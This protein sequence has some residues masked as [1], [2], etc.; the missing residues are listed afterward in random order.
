MLQAL[1]RP[2]YEPQID[3]LTLSIQLYGFLSHFSALR[4]IKVESEAVPSRTAILTSYKSVLIL[5]PLYVV[6]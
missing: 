6:I 1:W 3:D 4:Q 2:F 5:K